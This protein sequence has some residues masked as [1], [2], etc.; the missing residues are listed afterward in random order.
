[1]ATPLG[2]VLAADCQ[3]VHLGRDRTV[4]QV[5]AKTMGYDAADLGDSV[6]TLPL[7]DRRVSG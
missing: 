5:D 7:S 4:A 2:A 3:V 1:M 6:H